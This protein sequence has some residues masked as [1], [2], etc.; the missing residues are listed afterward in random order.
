LCDRVVVINKG[1]IVADDYLK[2][3]LQ[4][5]E[6]NVLIV[7][8]QEAININELSE[9]AGVAEVIALTAHKCRILPQPG[10]DLRSALFRYASDQQRSLI[11]LK[12]EENSMESIFKDLTS[13]Q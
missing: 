12:V 1:K 8:F 6:G 11:E 3:L 9:I 10:V 13:A 5:K 4:H 2:N 7:E